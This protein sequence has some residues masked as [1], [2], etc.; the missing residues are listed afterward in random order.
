MASGEMLKNSDGIPHSARYT[1]ATWDWAG[2][3]YAEIV[4]PKGC[5]T[6]FKI[7]N[8]YMLLYRLINPAKHSLKYTL[9]HRHAM[10]N[11]LLRQSSHRQVIEIAAGFS[12]RGAATSEMVDIQ[13][14]EVDKPN[15][16]EYKTKIL[17][18]TALG[19][20]VLSRSNFKQVPGDIL[21]LNYRNKFPNE[22]SLIISE[23][24]MMYFT[25]DEQL[26]IWR[27][28]ADFVKTTGSLYVFDYIPL[29]AEPKRS[30]LGEF[31]SRLKRH[32]G[33]KMSEYC[34]DERTRWQVRADLLTAGFSQVD[35][36]D[37]KDFA[38]RW[39]LPYSD[40]ATQ[41]LIYSCR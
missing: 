2:F 3:N 20:S 12:P 41:V 36:C 37:S 18:D 27:A 30:Q 7:V 24:L 34:Y 29:D 21:Q 32:L 10:I 5:R 1:A 11:T 40:K 14:F 6:L 22:S 8:T 13:Y 23:G 4:L 17:Q 19:R 15:V 33:T 28:I 25:R 9:L 38:S 35:I 31:L 26:T 16:I 39:R